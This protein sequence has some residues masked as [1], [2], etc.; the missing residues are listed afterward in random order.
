MERRVDA[1]TLKFLGPMRLQSLVSLPFNF[2]IFSSELGL[3]VPED[4]YNVL[5][6]IT[7]GTPL[8]SGSEPLDS[9]DPEEDEKILSLRVELASSHALM[10]QLNKQTKTK[11]D[12]AASAAALEHTKSAKLAMVQRVR[13]LFLSLSLYFP[14]RK[15]NSMQSFSYKKN[16]RE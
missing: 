12:R 10:A 9:R 15:V 14:C 5:Q 7:D 3:F 4:L 2:V 8:F 1:S 6:K 11:I 16:S 13:T